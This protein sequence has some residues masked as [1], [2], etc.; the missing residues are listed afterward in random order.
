MASGCAAAP[1]DGGANEEPKRSNSVSPASARHMIRQRSLRKMLRRLGLSRCGAAM[2]KGHMEIS[3]SESRALHTRLQLDVYEGVLY[4][5]KLAGDH[6]SDL[7]GQTILFIPTVEARCSWDPQ[8]Q[9]PAAAGVYEADP[10][11]GGRM[12]QLQLVYQSHGYYLCHQLA[13]SAAWQAQQH[14]TVLTH[15]R[16]PSAPPP[17]CRHP[18]CHRRHPCPRPGYRVGRS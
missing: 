13:P 17:H 14:V 10:L 2:E 6:A 4:D 5:V 1:R 8:L 11:V 15:H 16:P 7:D 9:A 18:R 3:I 12:Q